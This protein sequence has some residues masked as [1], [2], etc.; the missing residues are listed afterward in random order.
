MPRTASLPSWATAIGPGVIETQADEFYPEILAELWAD[1]NWPDPIAEGD[2]A[3]TD[4]QVLCKGLQRT[5]ADQYWL[6]VAYQC[7]KLDI[8]HAVGGTDLAPEKGGA[9]RIIIMDSSKVDG[10]W[11]QEGKPAGRG[12]ET[13]RKGKEARRHYQRIRHLVL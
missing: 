3:P 8:Q 6:E 4:E 5:E 13:A 7:A 12:V 9:L 11:A 10:T 2:E 1:E